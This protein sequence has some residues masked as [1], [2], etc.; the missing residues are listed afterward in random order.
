MMVAFAAVF[1]AVVLSLT[2]F[3]EKKNVVGEGEESND[4]LP[5]ISS[6]HFSY[7]ELSL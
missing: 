5:E 2:C 4:F 6:G 1:D 7:R 3:M